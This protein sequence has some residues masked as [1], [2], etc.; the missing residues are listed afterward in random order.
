MAVFFVYQ[1]QTYHAERVGKYAWS[2]QRTQNGKRNAGY[3]LMKEVCAG[4]FIIHSSGR[5]IVS[6]SIAQSNCYECDRPSDLG[7]E[8][9][10]NLDGYR[11]DLDYYD[12]SHPYDLAQEEDWLIANHNPAS[13]FTIQ[14]KGKQQYLCDIPPEQVVH[15]LSNAIRFERNTRVARVMQSAIDSSEMAIRKS[16]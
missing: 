10:W 15:L 1:N 12:L 4:D 6:I 3:E 8:D 11:I 5:K 9:L 2:P 14:G 16:R 13:P 7:G